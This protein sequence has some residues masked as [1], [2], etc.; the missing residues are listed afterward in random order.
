MNAFVVE[1]PNISKK[2]MPNV[3]CI[4]IYP[5]VF[6]AWGAD[7]RVVLTSLFKLSNINISPKI[8]LE[9]AMNLCMEAY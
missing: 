1:P 7:A 9:L 6:F 5:I 3:A 2:M 4:R 8:K